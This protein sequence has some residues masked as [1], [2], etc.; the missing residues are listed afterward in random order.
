VTFQQFDTV[1]LKHDLPAHGLR[2]GD[3]GAV[4]DVYDPDGL[5]VEFATASG[6]TLALLMLT[7]QDL[8]RATDDDLL[9]VR[10]LRAA[11]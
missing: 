6:R 5:H 2:T 4:V 1:V 10:S 7:E 8:R 3:I 9:A 11:V